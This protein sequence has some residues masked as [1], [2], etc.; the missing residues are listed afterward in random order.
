MAYENMKKSNMFLAVGSE[1][2]DA[3]TVRIGKAFNLQK[4]KQKRL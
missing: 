4:V 1:P 3:N 2:L